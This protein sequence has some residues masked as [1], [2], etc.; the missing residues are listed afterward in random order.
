MRQRRHTPTQRD[1]GDLDE[2]VREFRTIKKKHQE[3]LVS[4]AAR[5]VLGASV[6]RVFDKD[7]KEPLQAALGRIDPE[8]LQRLRTVAEF[9]R[10]YEREL[11]R[12][13]RVVRAT[14][15]GNHRIQP[16]YKWGHAAKV[17]SLFARDLVLNSRYFPDNIVRRLEPWLY[18]PID[19]IALRNLQRLGLRGFGTGIKDVGSR[20]QF[21]EIQDA[22]GT[23]A[24]RAGVPRVWFDD[25][26]L[27]RG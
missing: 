17:L 27:E 25:L 18:V 1:G 8:R 4:H 10:W 9:E 20:E 6:I 24:K 2:L 11:N 5:V 13:A 21:H 23:A 3:A 12:L 22:L 7:T 26:W 14:N 19:R 15:A 16:G